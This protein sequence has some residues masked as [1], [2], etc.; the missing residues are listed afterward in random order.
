MN[1][2][3]QTVTL[4]RGGHLTT[5]PFEEAAFQK[6]WEVPEISDDRLEA[7][8]SQIKP[9]CFDENG[10]LFYIEDVD[11]RSIAFAVS[12]TLTREVD[13]SIM[14]VLGHSFTIHHC[15]FYG[16]PYGLFKPSIAEVLS[17]VPEELLERVKAFSTE[18]PETSGEQSLV[19]SPC[20]GM[21]RAVTTWYGLKSEQ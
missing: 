3:L 16:S 10:K 19:V 6:Q 9:V 15:V 11:P 21:H 1:D 13:T 2:I 7:L 12:P 14:D 20:G 5:I 8:M 4:K 18:I 17:Q